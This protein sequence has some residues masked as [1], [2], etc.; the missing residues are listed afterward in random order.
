MVRHCTDP[1]YQHT[2]I[3]YLSH[4][5]NQHRFYIHKH[6]LYIH[7]P[8]TV[9]EG[10]RKTTSRSSNPHRET[11][12]HWVGVHLCKLIHLLLKPKELVESS[13]MLHTNLSNKQTRISDRYREDMKDIE[14]NKSKMDITELISPPP[15][16]FTY[17]ASFDYFNW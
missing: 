9:L 12:F 8:T 4:Y 7:S 14:L 13:F 11:I 6:L 2:K 5:Y 17:L 3:L 1:E 16:F 10:K 15:F